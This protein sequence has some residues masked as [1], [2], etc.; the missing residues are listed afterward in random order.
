MKILVIGL[1]ASLANPQSAA[2][3]R[4]CA[5]YAGWRVEIIVLAPGEA[6]RVEL[7][8]GIFV[9]LTGGKN[10]IDAL[11]R[12]IRLAR[13]FVAMEKPDIVTAQDPL[14]TGLVAWFVHGHAKLHIQ[15]HSGIFERKIRTR[16]EKLF[17]PLSRFIVRR[18][19]RVRTVS[20]RGARG[21]ERIG[22][23][24]RQID[25]APIAT[26]VSRFAAVPPPNWSAKHVLCVSRLEWEKGVD[27]LLEAWPSVVARIPDAR[28]RIVGAGSQE[29]SL[30]QQA[31][32]RGVA[33]S[34]EFVGWRADVREDLV[35]SSLVVQPS[36]FE[37][38]G[39]SVIEAVASGRPVVMT[40]VGAAGEVIRDDES[41]RVVPVENPAALSNALVEVLER[42][43][44]GAAFAERAREI[45]QHLPTSNETVQ[46]IRESF[47]QTSMQR[48]LVLA[49]A[50]DAHDALF[51]FFLA[52]LSEAAR[53]FGEITVLA[54]R[55]GEYELPSTVRVIPLRPA[56]SR[57]RLLV[58]WNLWKQSWALRRSYDGVFI[59]GDYQYPVLAGW[60]WKLLGKK[61]VFWYAHY[62]SRTPWLLVASVFSDEVVTSVPEAN[63]L[64]RAVSIGQAI[65]DSRFVSDGRGSHSSL[66]LLMLGRVSSVKRVPWV[67]DRVARVRGA[68]QELRIIG[69]PTQEDEAKRLREAVERTHA[70]WE[71]R[72]YSVDEAPSLYREADVFL[73]ATPGSLDKTI[74]EAA[75]SG[76]VVI[77]TTPAFGSQVPE[78]LRW[79]CPASEEMFEEAARRVCSMSADERRAVGQELR[80]WAVERHSMRRQI[81]RLHD[82]FQR[83]LA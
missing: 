80:A 21:L 37:G 41:G 40:D 75:L 57:S 52:W 67:V 4:Q 7:A 65:D 23:D 68:A 29:A 58:I 51:G 45:V 24:P 73:N 56:T 83:L 32:E 38:W 11:R 12:G 27:V 82:I 18:A 13:R 62:T 15:D 63:A 31:T 78:G 53:Y 25:V 61:V 5:Y 10:K 42:P 43:D 16:T 22:I 44:A 55:V 33:D 36:R 66:R 71:E 60:L 49:Q 3:K 76:C 59:R 39:L 47:Q 17:A 72:D 50:V 69:R 6:A 54:L 74:V 2:A 35:W 26:D 28:L 81:A 9:Q 34:V 77:A 46:L 79:L 1:D 30:K 48:L 70:T 8:P 14:W 19:K 20:A 64:R